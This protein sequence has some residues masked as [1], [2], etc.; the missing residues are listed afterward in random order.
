[1]KADSL[2][3]MPM[4]NRGT[5]ASSDDRR[6]SRVGVTRIRTT[7]ARIERTMAPRIHT[8]RSMPVAKSRPGIKL[9]RSQGRNHVD[10]GPKCKIDT[11]PKR[12]ALAS[13]A[14]KLGPT[15]SML[16]NARTP[17]MGIANEAAL[18]S[19]DESQRKVRMRARKV[20]SSGSMKSA[21]VACSAC[22]AMDRG[23]AATRPCKW[24]TGYRGGISRVRRT[25][26]Q[27]AGDAEHRPGHDRREEVGRSLGEGP[28]PRVSEEREGECR[29][30]EHSCREPDEMS[31]A[32]GQF[33]VV[34][35][36]MPPIPD[37][38]DR[39]HREETWLPASL[40][41]AVN[42]T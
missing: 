11:S 17:I 29:R 15:P 38:C 25:E 18:N 8:S 36:V 34:S 20:S 28:C 30:A 4:L 13:E 31:D 10:S 19:P 9:S 24:R 32:N 41:G 16:P 39:C 22:V 3:S 21:D 12:H 27:D 2:R 37:L 5:E 40:G 23:D 42:S 1:M 7:S 26:L 35:A 6:P 14:R 33:G